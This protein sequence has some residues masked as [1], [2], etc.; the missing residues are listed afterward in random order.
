MPAIETI[1]LTKTYQGHGGCREISLAVPHGCIFGLLGPNGAG[2]STLVKM[3]V[4]LL[5][6]TSGEARLLGRPLEDVSVRKRIGFLPEGFRY[7]DWLSGED[8]LRFHASLYGLSS[9]EASER[10][11]VVL[12]MVG[13]GEQGRK[14]VGAY[15][16]GMQ[17]R[18][19]LACALLS[20]PELVFL[21]EPTSA[22]DPIGRKEVRDL[23]VQLRARGKTVFLNSHLLSEL[24]TVCDRIAIIKQGRLLFQGDWREL[25]GPLRQARVVV[26]MGIGVGVDTAVT[27]GAPAAL[28]QELTLSGI[29]LTKATPLPAEADKPPRAEWLLTW[30][31][32][33]PDIPRL[34]ETLVRFGIPV[35]EVAPLAGSLEELFLETIANG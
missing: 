30:S 15:S 22:L 7:H 26:S 31:E 24:E 12:E 34:V 16:K 19:G 8:L 6:P 9:R 4:G 14:R 2:K 11:P 27:L 5:Q 32:N 28:T 35:H 17:Q 18:I 20:D 13:L 3:L 29:T 33:P 1:E 21:D 23:L 10:I 25:A